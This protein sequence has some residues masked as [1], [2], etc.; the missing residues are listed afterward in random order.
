MGV[1]YRVAL[2][3]AITGIFSLCDYVLRIQIDLVH[4]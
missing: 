2:E 4:S 1:K 3:V